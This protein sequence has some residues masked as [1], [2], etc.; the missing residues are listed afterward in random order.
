MIAAINGNQAFVE[1]IVSTPSMHEEL[2]KVDREGRSALI[3]SILHQR[4]ACAKI[5]VTV[6]GELGCSM[7]D[8]VTP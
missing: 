1:K 8:G 4:V 7:P 5:L 2:G 6:P 3:L